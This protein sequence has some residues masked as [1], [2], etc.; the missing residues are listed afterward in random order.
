[1]M[2]FFVICWRDGIM[3]YVP[4]V[5]MGGIVVGWEAIRAQHKLRSEVCEALNSEKS[6]FHH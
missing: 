2:L 4:E 5:V 1:M 3:C 6:R